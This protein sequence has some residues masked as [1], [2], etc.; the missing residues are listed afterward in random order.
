[1]FSLRILYSD[2]TWKNNPINLQFHWSINQNNIISVLIYANFAFH[3]ITIKYANTLLLANF[4]SVWQHPN[5]LIKTRLF[6]GLERLDIFVS[7][8]RHAKDT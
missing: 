2:K 5:A 8:F 4:S 1:M 7:L 6:C 3:D